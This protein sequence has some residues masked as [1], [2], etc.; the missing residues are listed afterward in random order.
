MQYAI[1]VIAT[2]AIF[3][4]TLRY[5]Y[6]VDDDN[7][8][9]MSFKAKEYLWRN[10]RKVFT[11][12]AWRVMYGAGLLRDTRFDHGFTILVTACIGCLL[13]AAFGNI[14]LSLLWVAH[15]ANNQLTMWLNGRRYQLS[16]LLGLAA[17]VWI[18]AGIVLWPLAIALHPIALPFVLLAA[19]IKTPW[20]LLWLLP[21]LRAVP[22]L[23]KWMQSRLVNV[24]EEH[25]QKWHAW[26]LV[27]GVE[28]LGAYW[29]DLL[30]PTGVR[31]YHPKIWGYAEF[32]DNLK[33]MLT[34]REFIGP[35]LLTIAVGAL[36]LQS[37]I[38]SVGF[39]L[40]LVAVLPWCGMW[41][42]PTQLWAQRYAAVF[43]IGGLMVVLGTLEHLPSDLRLAAHMVLLTWYVVLTMKDMNAYKNIY[44]HFWK[45]LVNEPH[46]ENVAHWTV[47]ICNENGVQFN[48]HGMQNEALMNEIYTLAAGFLW[49][50]HNPEEN[51]L[52]KF[53]NKKLVQ[54]TKQGGT[55]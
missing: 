14:W 28:A 45:Q 36:A 24:N 29:F 17:Y 43:N 26:K 55:Q 23:V 38:G 12:Q 6:V 4:R 32:P 52:H 25:Y 2:I 5:G 46:N 11:L 22:W 15:P 44:M 9:I 42:N 37:Y 7:A 54:H 10:P 16:L 47:S 39:V 8:A 40:A 49:C 19:V 30:V 13:Y 35:A 53:I 1:I 41:L 48:K 34:W 18:P 21:G 31:M 33:R 3:Y 50:M 27:T 51:H 20:A